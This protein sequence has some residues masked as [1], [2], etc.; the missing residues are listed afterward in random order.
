[1]GG[2]PGTPLSSHPAKPGPETGDGTA[3]AAADPRRSGRD[4]P[5]LVPVAAALLFSVLSWA[6][7]CAGACAEAH[8]YR[9]YGIPLPPIGVAFFSSC[10]LSLLIRRR[11]THADAVL[12]LL[13]SGALGSEIVFLWTQKF[14]IGEWCPLC[15]GIAVSMATACVV[16]A[17]ERVPRLA[18]QM[19][20]QERSLAM[21]K[22]TRN[23]SLVL[24]A[25][26]VGVLVS[27]VGL[28]RHD[29]HAAVRSGKALSFGIPDGSSE[30]YVVTDW[31]CPPCRAAE[32]E[33]ARGARLAMKQAKVV[34]VDY[35]GHQETLNF[36]P[37]NMAFMIREKE[38]YLRIREALF[39]LAQT[40]REPTP[41]DVQ[42]AVAPLGVKYVALNY[43]DVAAGTEYFNGVM[44][45]F[46]V[47]RTPT[48]VVTDTKTGKTKLL[49]GSAEI[50]SDN[51]MKAL[52]EVLAK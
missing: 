14:V 34:F 1:M 25:F 3:S 9:L 12:I 21:R 2:L 13:L 41:E 22:L 38:A 45:K 19:R 26:A 8:R 52:A 39:A 10:L 23:S 43:A 24:T 36:V 11:L 7:V 32:S 6:G 37:Y 35:P 46:K 50:T 47:K 16:L 15:V 30:V 44:Q 27:A 4:L 42:A 5:A 20:S 31:F 17:G 49:T 29:A 40:T 33:I 48:V 28:E 51:I 18:R